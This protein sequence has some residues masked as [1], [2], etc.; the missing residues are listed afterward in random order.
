MAESARRSVDEL[1]KSE[2]G[3]QRVIPLPRH[4]ML[5][6]DGRPQEKHEPFPGTLSTLTRPRWA[7]TTART[8][9]KPSP[10]PRC[11]RLASPR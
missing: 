6:P 1:W 8:K 2:G 11:E 4:A 3:P 9:L 5:G 7:R 10:R